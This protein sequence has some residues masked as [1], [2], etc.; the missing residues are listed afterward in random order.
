MH[1]GCTYPD[2][3]RNSSNL[4][5][6]YLYISRLSLILIPGPP[7]TVATPLGL[8]PPSPRFDTLILCVGI[9]VQWLFFPE[10][11]T[12]L[13]EIRPRSLPMFVEVCRI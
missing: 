10:S 9:E 5:A 7:D 8:P 12:L 2:L 13:G 6:R 4:S 11:R 1:R 3:E